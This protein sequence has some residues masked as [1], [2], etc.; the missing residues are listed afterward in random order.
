MSRI[1]L[2]DTTVRDG[3]QSLW[4]ANAL[5]TPMIAAIAPVIARVG[6]RAI[7]FTSSTHMAMSVRWH[8]EDPWERIRVVRELMPEARLGFITPGMRFMAWERAPLDV[9]RL[10]LRCVIRNGVDR[11]WVAESMNDVETALAIARIAKEEGAAEVLVGLV[12]SVSPV[13][14]DDYYA[15]RAAAI[16]ASPDVDVLNLKDPGGLLTPERARTLVP[17]LRRAAP[18][19]P[20]EVHSHCTATTA[21]LTYLEAARLG[22]S[23][24]CTAVR[25]LA[26][27]TSQPSAESTLAN[28]RGEGFEVDVD[29]EA[30]AETSAYFTELAVRL[31]RPLGTPLEYDAAVYRHQL[32]GGM[33]S[34][35]RRQ[36]AEVGMA[37]RWDDVLAELPRVRE[38]LGWP[39]MVTPLSQFVGVQAFLNVTTGRRYSQVPDEVV[40]YVLG[41]YGPPP[42]EIDPEVAAKVLAS[43]KAEKLRRVEHR[44]DLA[45]ARARYGDR[46]S[47]ELLLLRMTLPAE[48]VDAMLAARRRLSAQPGRHALVELV[49]GI[50]RRAPSG[51]EV[52]AP[53]VRLRARRRAA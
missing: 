22:A 19:L 31:G 32:P 23:F 14:T 52:D 48:Q 44:L 41:Q 9:M 50:V 49:E 7:D 24:L 26:N 4:S 33:T 20:L 16:A 29:D 2:V 38:E 51:V 8:R 39:V 21:P 15:V 13:H 12:Y 5:T 43:P 36:L 17:A 35:L 27:G 34:T 40:K 37:N 47:D 53:G 46:I 10:A 45:E 25:P 11:I 28:L 18:G 1:G 6:Y 3:H 42:G 30:L